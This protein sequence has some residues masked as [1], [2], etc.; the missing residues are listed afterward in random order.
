MSCCRARRPWP[1]EPAAGLQKKE[2]KYAK[3]NILRQK[4]CA[5]IFACGYVH[6]ASGRRKAAPLPAFRLRGCRHT[7]VCIF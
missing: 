2:K 5:K 7:M 6:N 1:E 3:K 4:K